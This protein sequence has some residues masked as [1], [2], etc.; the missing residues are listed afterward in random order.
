MVKQKEGRALFLLKIKVCSH[1]CI[2]IFLSTI[3]YRYM[4]VT[5]NSS[6]YSAAKADPLIFNTDL[7]AYKKKKLR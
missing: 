3:L 4:I 6:F 2:L 7:Y 5:E 1:G